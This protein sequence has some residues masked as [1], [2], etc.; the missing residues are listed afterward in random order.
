MLSSAHN[1]CFLGHLLKQA[2]WIGI[3]C[4]PLLLHIPML[5]N[6][7]AVHAIEITDRKQRIDRDLQMIIANAIIKAPMHQIKRDKRDDIIQLRG[8]RVGTLRTIWGVFDE[9][10]I[11]VFGEGAEDVFLAQEL[12]EELLEDPFLVRGRG[13]ARWAVG[14]FGRGW[15]GA[16]VG[17]RNWVGLRVGDWVRGWVGK[18]GGRKGEEAEEDADTHFG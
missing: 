1:P 16:A 15:G 14:G 10:R 18:E 13:F 2:N 9:A 8:I 6:A 3:P 4:R 5:D 12:V 11:D 7:R 17:L